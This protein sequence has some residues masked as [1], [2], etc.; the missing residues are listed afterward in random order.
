MTNKTKQHIFFVDDEPKIWKAVC[1]TLEQLGTKV[2]CFERAT[3]CLEQLR[4]RRC[5]LLITDVKMP[6]MDGLELLAEV[7]RILPKLPVLVITGYGDIPMA[8]KALKK[9]ASDFIEKPFN[10]QSFLAAVESALKHKAAVE[11]QA[12]KLLTRVEL[13]VLHLVLQ[14][15]TSKEI[16]ALRKRELRTIQDQR[17]SIYRKLKVRNLAELFRWAVKAGLIKPPRRKKR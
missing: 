1:R 5:D 15:K 2:S 6:E 17:A 9:G 3:D 11:A 8:V 10:R 16:A 13:Q 14:G 12:L 4:K 7:K